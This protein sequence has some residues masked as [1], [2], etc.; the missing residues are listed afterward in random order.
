MPGG[1]ASNGDSF[2]TCGNGVAIYTSPTLLTEATEKPLYFPNG[3]KGV[4]ILT[5][6]NETYK[7]KPGDT[8]AIRKGPV[9]FPNGFR[10]DFSCSN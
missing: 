7:L 1:G 9:F 2:V 5:S 10:F 8:N 4:E 6:N 3:F